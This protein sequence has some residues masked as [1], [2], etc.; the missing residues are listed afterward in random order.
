MY[1]QLARSIFQRAFTAIISFVM[2]TSLLYPISAYAD[3]TDQEL[4]TPAQTT[5]T[6]IIDTAPTT[7]SDTPAETATPN[8][9][10]TT[11]AT[12]TDA[13]PQTNTSVVSNTPTT[14]S[15]GQTDTS[16]SNAINSDAQTGNALGSQNTS[17]GDITSG[18]AGALA[19]IVNLL[20]S[21]V[22][23]NG[24]QPLVFVTDI[25]GNVTGDLLIDPATLV[26]AIGTSLPLYGNSDPS[27]ASMST[28]AV[29]VNT[30]NVG[31]ESGNASAIQNTNA[32]T[33]QSGDANAVVN[34]MNLI[35]SAVNANQSFVGVVN[36]Y[37]N[38][39]GDILVPADFVNSILGVGTSASDTSLPVIVSDQN[40][41]VTNTINATAQSG[42]A[43]SA[44]NSTSGSVNTGQ[45]VTK[46]TIL[47]LTSSQT[48]SKN[49]LL[50]FVNV[51]GNWVGL[52]LDAPPGTTSASLGDGSATQNTIPENSNLQS[53]TDLQINNNINVAA[54][55]G[56]ALGKE[57][58]TVGNIASG[59]AT[60]SVN[61]IN[62]LNSQ[63]SLSDWFGVLFINVFGQ[64]K[65]NFG[66][67][68]AVA[69]VPLVNSSGQSTHSA[70]SGSSPVSAFT[71][72]PA[73]NKKMYTSRKFSNLMRS[74][75][76]GDTG[77]ITMASSTVLG[78]S[79]HKA[80]RNSNGTDKINLQ[81]QKEDTVK[82]Q[83]FSGWLL[84]LVVLVIIAIS[85]ERFYV[86]TARRNRDSKEKEEA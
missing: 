56:N 71:F 40:A 37:G 7:S 69:T 46:L 58:T 27:T 45:A 15:T 44:D 6:Q 66:A 21:S 9:T 79:T 59:K 13:V 82:D 2:V 42:S 38:L 60:A 39:E 31:A 18:N 48:T 14:Q 65:G 80:S 55:S 5:P 64:W 24:A 26:N 61:L 8:S 49:A 25:N 74:S 1:N 11:P 41:T 43:L 75:S 85:A 50:V 53:T 36:I 10:D 3:A 29:I 16:L 28:R 33:V 52:I 57:N 47:N 54:A 4:I 76:V 72:I 51:L 83:G 35:N 20:Q 77:D 63:I 32:G 81:V 12:S 30:A 22:N 70:Q 78:D 84:S 23:L 86:M 62:I 68:T 34:I 19:T 17:V 67:R 73:N